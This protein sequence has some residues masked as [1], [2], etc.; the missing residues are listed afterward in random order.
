MTIP[1]IS[2]A[3][4]PWKVDRVMASLMRVGKGRSRYFA[5]GPVRRERSSYTTGAAFCIARIQPLTRSDRIPSRLYPTL[6][7]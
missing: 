5:R 7:S 6:M 4:Q 3:G 2:A 1:S